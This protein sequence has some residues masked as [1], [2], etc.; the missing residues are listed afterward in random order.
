MLSPVHQHIPL[1]QVH[2]PQGNDSPNKW[3]DVF[4]WYADYCLLSSLV[5]GCACSL[6]AV[7]IL[8]VVCHIPT[9]V[10]SANLLKHSTKTEPVH[11]DCLTRACESEC[12]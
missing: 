7:V 1:L 8:M 6:V 11:N 2:L 9:A 5:H 10:V 4:L 3:E 12:V